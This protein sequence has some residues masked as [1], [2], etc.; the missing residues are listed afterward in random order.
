MSELGGCVCLLTV[1]EALT[2]PVPQSRE[3]SK[4]N[5]TQILPLYVFK[6]DHQGSPTVSFMVPN[7]ALYVLS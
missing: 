2:G 4:A 6:S 1:F 5:S 3:Q 7:P